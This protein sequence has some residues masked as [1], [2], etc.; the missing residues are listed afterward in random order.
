MM[1]LALLEPFHVWKPE[2]IRKRFEYRR[3]G[4]WV[5]GVRVY[6]REEPWTID[7]TPE[8]LGCKSWVT[9]ETPLSTEGLR[10]VLPPEAASGRLDRAPIS[11]APEARGFLMPR[12][13]D[14][15]PPRPATSARNHD[16]PCRDPA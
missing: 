7:P 6:R 8:Q 11:P 13:G 4:L 15:E 14:L 10:P 12:D 1:T 16:H 3:P 2:T 9:L 5:L